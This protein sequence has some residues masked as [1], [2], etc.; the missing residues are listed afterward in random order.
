[1]AKDMTSGNPMKLISR[2]TLPLLIGNVFQQ[3]YNMADTYFVGR[4]IGVQALAA[5]GST[6]S[7]VFFIIG[8]AISMTAG[9][10]IPLAQ[11]FGAKDMQGVKRS[12]YVSTLISIGATI[13]LTTF[14]MLFCRQILEIMQTPPEIIDYAYEYLMVI[15]AGIFAQIAFN[16]LSNIIRAIGDAITP[17]YFLVLSCILVC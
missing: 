3:F 4:Y 6:G 7:I 15:F 13:L 10:A 17:L 9:L 2:F 11:K 5:V 1:M 14:S 8:F 12:F 16:L